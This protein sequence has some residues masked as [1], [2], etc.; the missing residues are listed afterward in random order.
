MAGCAS[1]ASLAARGW[2]VTLIER[3]ASLAEEAS[4]N[5]QGVL[6]LKL[7]AHG[8]AL[9]RLIVSGFGHTRRL[10]QRLQ[11]GE[12]WSD[13]G[14]LQLGFD[15][16]EA[17]RQ[18]KLAEAFPGSLL[19]LLDKAEAESLAGVGLPAGGLFYPEVAGYIRRPCAD[20]WR[21]IRTSA[22][23]PARKSACN[24]KPM[25]GAPGAATRNLPARPSPSLP[26]PPRCA[27][28]KAHRACR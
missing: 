24:A 15:E 4:G 21:S 7:S 9:S 27:A 10:I 28:S 19:R 5:P 13:C 3:H 16:A 8:T 20:T 6:Y 23:W 12:E 1:A 18:A 25:A 17:G 22:Y 26:P 11:K 2:Q 14:V